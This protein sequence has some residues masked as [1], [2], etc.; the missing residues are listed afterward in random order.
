[1]TEREKELM[2]NP[3]EEETFVDT[4]EPKATTAFPTIAIAVT[5]LA[6]IIVAI[7]LMLYS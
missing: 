5:V 2:T 1:M 6:I 7:I 3:A 4:A